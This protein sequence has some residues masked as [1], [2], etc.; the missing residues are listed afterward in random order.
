MLLARRSHRLYNLYLLLCWLYSGRDSFRETYSLYNSITVEG[1]GMN[2]HGLD[3]S[4]DILI[5]VKM[6]VLLG[7]PLG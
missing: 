4:E 2:E 3:I 7:A 6:I 1:E 5:P